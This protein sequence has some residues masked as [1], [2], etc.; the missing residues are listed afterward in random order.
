MLPL[1][2]TFRCLPAVKLAQI[3][4]TI[5][6]YHF[7]FE[8]SKSRDAPEGKWVLGGGIKI[9]FI[10]KMYGRIDQKKYLRKN[11]KETK[12]FFKFLYFIE[13]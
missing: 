1:Q 12:Q 10:Y 5:K 13:T 11:I 8:S 7:C 9:S 6:S 4:L 2:M 3:S